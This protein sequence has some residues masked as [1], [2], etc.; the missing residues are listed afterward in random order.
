ML[1][2]TLGRLN[3]YDAVKLMKICPKCKKEKPLDE[4]NSQAK[5]CIFCHRKNNENWRKDNPEKV[6]E[7]HKKHNK[8]RS[9]PKKKRSNNKKRKANNK[10]SSNTKNNKTSSNKKSNKTKREQ[11]GMSH[12]TAAAKLRKILLFSLAKKCGMGKCI[13]CG[14]KLTLETFSIDHVTPWLHSDNPIKLY[15]DIDNIGFSHLSCNVK[16]SR[17]PK[18]RNKEWPD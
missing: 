3:Y 15:F 17:P 6:L 14:K 13:R 18:P 2:L 11:L 12:S 7:S 16:E 8:K 4:F 9:K 10:T 1:R 5:Y